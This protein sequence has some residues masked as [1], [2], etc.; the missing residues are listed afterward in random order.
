MFGDNQILLQINVTGDANTVVTQLT[1]NIQ[2]LNVTSVKSVS[3][4]IK[5]FGEWSLVVN[6]ITQTIQG[7]GQ[8]LRGVND[9]AVAFDKSLQE[10]SAITGV[11]GEGLSEIGDMAQDVA[12]KFGTD[13][14]QGVE[15]FKLIL[16][17]LSPELGKTPE[18][19]KKMGEDIAT[20]SKTMGGDVTAAAEVLTTA[21]NQF[22]VSLDD[23]IAAEEEMAK[24][25][26]VMAAAAKEGS[27]EL[28]QIQEALK[29]S[30]MAAKAAGVSF[31]EAN[32]AIQVLDK[33]GRKGSEGGV[34][35]RNVMSTLAQGR[36]LPKDVQKELKGAGVDINILTDRSRS[37]QERLETLKPIMQ[38]QAL[39]SKLFGRENASSAIALISGTEELGEYKDAITGTNT[40]QEQADTIMQSYEERHKRLQAQ[41]EGLKLKMFDMTGGITMYVQTFG[42]MLVPLAQMIPLFT[43]VAKGI[44]GMGTAIKM[45]GPVFTVLKT[46]AISACRAIGVAIM[47]IPIIGWIAAIIAA[48]IALFVYF[49]NTSV[50]FRAVVKGAWAYVVSITQEAWGVL[51]KIFGNIADMIKAAITLD[52]DGVKKAAKGF[53]EVFKDFGKK[54]AEAYNKA[55]NE[56]MAK[57]KKAEEGKNKKNAPKKGGKKNTGNTG[58]TG[59]NNDGN[60]G[61]G[62]SGNTGGTGGGY[63]GGY[64]G[65]SGSSSGGTNRSITTNIQNLIKG[66]IIIKTVNMKES[67]AEIKRVIIEALQDATNEVTMA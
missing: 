45:L 12:K 27:A 46:G 24:M 57:E 5:K 51:K 14:A 52:F 56:E 41:I 49:W 19:M 55:Y 29:Q 2:S 23:P 25:M 58:G 32:A 4:I 66:D 18:V 60:N 26:N 17:Q 6:Q 7:V 30:G 37:L 61:G 20:L 9:P 42:E 43:G 28:P 35:L 59:G 22:Q 31:E 13:A 15:S 67:A 11:S 50:K 62:N 34:A 21:M 1:K 8:A 48:L 16:S 65:G 3:N 10:L 39:L 33:A 40:A 36:F 54:S 53:T 64:D 47:N 44:R 38:D 63:S